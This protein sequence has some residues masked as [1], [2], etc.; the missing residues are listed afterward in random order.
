VTLHL[1]TIQNTF[2]Q[3]Q[4]IAVKEDSRVWWDM[5]TS[6]LLKCYTVNCPVQISH[7]M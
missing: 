6:K 2:V 1:R 7:A 3:T 5:T 4:D